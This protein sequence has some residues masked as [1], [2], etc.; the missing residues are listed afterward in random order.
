MNM[1][2]GEKNVKVPVGKKKIERAKIY[3]VYVPI[4][5]HPEWMYAGSID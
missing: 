1:I 3:I 5:N 4:V 2:M